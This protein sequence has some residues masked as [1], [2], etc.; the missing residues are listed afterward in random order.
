M[1]VD[2]DV[3]LPAQFLLREQGAAL[4]GSAVLALTRAALE[5]ARIT[6]RQDS[7]FLDPSTTALEVYD[8]TQ[9]LVSLSDLRAK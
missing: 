2:D 6:C 1:A 8:P 5:R 3:T 7:Y 9:L 4:S